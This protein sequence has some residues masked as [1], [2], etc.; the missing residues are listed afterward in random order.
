MGLIRLLLACLVVMYHCGQ[1][2]GFKVMQG[3]QAVESFYIISG[4]YMALILN[5]KYFFQPNKYSLFITNRFLRIFPVYW[6]VLA[7]IFIFAFV[8]S[9]LSGGQDWGAFNSFVQYGK[10]FNFFTWISIFFS[11]LFFLGQDL[12]M[13]LGV[14]SSGAL[15]FTKNYALTHPQLNFFLFVPQGWTLSI[16]ILFYLIAPFIVRK[17]SWIIMGLL[18]LSLFI[19]IALVK[20]GYTYDPWSYRF[21]PSELMFF[22]L[23]SLAYKLYVFLKSK[24][25]PVNWLIFVFVATLFSILLFAYLHYYIRLYFYFIGLAFAIPFIFSL[26]KSWKWDR[27]LG[28]YSFTIYISHLLVKSIV[29]YVGFKGDNVSIQVLIGSFCLSFFLNKYVAEKVEI[30]RQRRILQPI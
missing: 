14:N 13:F 21:F 8:R 5:E 10:Q 27:Y 15:F 28:E 3:P 6:T 23:G 16:E 1:F 24:T 25:I 17:S 22:L 9:S 30:I 18:L 20:N 7:L 12:F 4:F 11:N 29:Y 19:K 26:T 2:E